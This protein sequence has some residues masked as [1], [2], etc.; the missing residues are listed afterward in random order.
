MVKMQFGL[1]DIKQLLK[2]SE[3]RIKA[4]LINEFNEI[5]NKKIDEAIVAIQTKNETA[6]KTIQ[7]QMQQQTAEIEGLQDPL[8]FLPDKYEELKK[9]TEK[10]KEEHKNMEK[11]KPQMSNS[12]NYVKDQNQNLCEQ[13]EALEQYGRK[14][15]IEF[16]GIPNDTLMPGK[17]ENINEKIK[18]HLL[19]VGYQLNTNNISA[20]HRLKTKHPNQPQPIIMRFTNRNV[21]TKI[22]AV[23]SLFHPRKF[24]CKQSGIPGL[25]RLYINENLTSQ[26][27]NLFF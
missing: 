21:R 14:K 11:E 18:L 5:F 20:S 22:F 24:D 15:N 27:K 2:E 6:L 19:K 17:S 3:E 10:L 23:R 26:R 12:I 9:E 4:S 16:H 8:S 7:V 25:T 13:L 1:D